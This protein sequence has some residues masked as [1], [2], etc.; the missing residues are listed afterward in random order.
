MA[1]GTKDKKH[2]CSCGRS[3]R[4]AISLKRHQNVT[5]CSGEGSDEATAPAEAEAVKEAAKVAPT[6]AAA[7]QQDD[8]TVV[9]TPELVAAWQQ[10]TGFQ[11]RRGS[12]VDSLPEAQ[13]A[14]TQIDWVA[15][16]QTSKAFLQFC[17]EV[18]S[19]TFRA[20]RSALLVVGRSALFLSVILLTG[21]LMIT[22]VSAS[23]TASIDEIGRSQL[24]AQTLVQDFLQNARLNQY[25][26]AH[27]LLAPGAR[28]SVTPDQLKIMFNSLPLNESPTTWS[29]DISKDLSTAQVTVTRAGLQEVYTVVLGDGGWG[30]SSV[31]IAG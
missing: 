25:K 7:S 6:P 22:G 4:H 29:T 20:M 14:A 10:Q 16:G 13:P 18:Q 5:G 8:R 15:V 1:S 21:W 17:G 30:V 26:R 11:A 31:S 27:D 2:K 23:D 28:Q 3:F 24:A 12:V 9:I 19:A